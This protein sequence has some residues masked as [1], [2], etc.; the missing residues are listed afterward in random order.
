M[1][2][3]ENYKDCLAYIDA[4]WDKITHKPE[5]R[6]VN[7]H[8]ITIPH[9]YVTPN[10]KWRD[11]WT[12]VF[13]WDTFFMFR[14]LIRTKR[15][16][17][18]RS[19]VDNFVYLFATYGIIPN[20]SAPT[21]MG[22][23]QPPFFTSMILDTYNGYYFAHLGKNKFLQMFSNLQKHKKWLREAIGFAKK[24]Y[25]TVWLDPEGLFHHSVSGYKLNRY[26]DR[27]VGYAHS[28][29]L[30][31]GWDFTSRFYNRCDHFLPV[32]LNVYL[33]KY[34]RDFAKIAF[35]LG[36]SDDEKSWWQIALNRKKDIQKLMWNEKEGFF[37]DYD[38]KAKK[39]SKFLSLG[40]FTPL[41]AGLAEPEQ[42]ELMIKKLPIF[43][44][45]HGLVVTA[46]ES[47]APQIKLSSIPQEY[48]SAIEDVL[49]PKQWD[50]PY[51]WP[52]L[53]YLTVIGLLKYGF[54]EDAVRI[55]TSSLAAHAKVFR[56]HK[57]FYEKIDA[58]SG[59]KPKGFHYPNQFG[60]GWTNAVFYRYVKILDEIEKGNEIYVRPKREKPP[61]KLSVPH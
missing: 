45:K 52:P 34:E 46:K 51:S 1:T 41:W 24:E 59:E 49:K 11:K 47:L 15:E 10:Q 40:G 39:Q 30:E 33:F 61:Y 32:D 20:F 50:Y 22:R 25:E 55:M 44:T 53:E 18:L 14:G 42:A 31:S 2:N 56:K 48:R 4:Y 17:L 27:D 35:H 54:V 60:F 12:V 6:I 28:S 16:W 43:E 37:F 13:Y 5:Q 58:V 57:T 26:G 19:M 3:E 23:S 8:V 7:H 21:S 38:Y 36:D 9:P 29:E